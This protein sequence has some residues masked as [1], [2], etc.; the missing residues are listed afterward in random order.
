MAYLQTLSIARCQ[1]TVVVRMRFLHSMVQQKQKT[2]K[3]TSQCQWT[4]AR[5]KA[6]I[7]KV[8]DHSS[9]RN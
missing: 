2:K 8:A 7:S 6:Y 9:T 3:S 5:S 1:S 4:A